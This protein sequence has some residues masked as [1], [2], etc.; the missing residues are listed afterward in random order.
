[1]S[2]AINQARHEA[3]HNGTNAFE[4]MVFEMA[5]TV[6]RL[7]LSAVHDV[8][9][10]DVRPQPRSLSVPITVD[11]A[12]LAREIERQLRKL[13]VKRAKVRTMPEPRRFVRG[14]GEINLDQ[15]AEAMRKLVADIGTVRQQR[16]TAQAAQVEAEQALAKMTGYRDNALHNAIS[17]GRERDQLRA[18]LDKIN[19]LAKGGNEE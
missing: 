19:S 7:A 2:D 11:P 6:Q 3:D 1:M 9:V 16:D 5:E 4:A 13:K 15:A 12:A 10:N 14:W 8:A 17:A 18:T